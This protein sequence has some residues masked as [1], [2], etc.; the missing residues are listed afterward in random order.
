M[1]ELLEM[2]GICKYFPG[3]TALKDVD[4]IL[5]PGEVHALVGENGA[6]KSTLMKIMTGKY[7]P[8]EGTV[9]MEGKKLTIHSP[10][11]SIMQGISMI[12]QE[13]NSVPA[14]KVY[15]NIFLGRENQFKNNGL[16]SK[17]MMRKAAQPFLDEVGATFSSNKEMTE[18]N[19]AELQLVEIARA[20]SSNCKV[21][22]L[23]EP[24]SSLSNREVESL[25]GVI[26]RLKAKGIGLVFIGHRLEEVMRVA[27]R[28][29]VLRDGHLIET[30]E[31][32]DVTPQIM[33]QLMVGRDVS[34]IYPKVDAEIGDVTVSVRGYTNMP[35]FKDVSFDVRA[36]EI[37]GLGGLVGA[38][39]TETV[40]TIF[41]IRKKE[42]GQLFI[43]GKEVEI[44]K[45]ADAIKLGIGMIT[46]DRRRYGLNLAETVGSNILVMA[47]NMMKDK[48]GLISDKK[49][50]ALAK[51]QIETF[52]VKTTGYWQPVMNLSG[53]NQQKVIFAK[54]M[55][56]TPD[57][58]ILDEPTR[59]IDVGAK[60]EI[61][62]I[63]GELAKAGKTI[64]MISSEMP[65]LMGMTDRIL[66][67]YEG[68]PMGIVERKDYKEEKIM[69]LASG[70]AEDDNSA[71]AEAPADEKVT[72]EEAH[73]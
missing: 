58:L 13:L 22:V 1:S 38:G 47:T 29:T 62:K 27:D 33:V 8:D 20:I 63:I 67:M 19:I 9:S 16:V 56:N 28:V 41:G 30:R 46:E 66:V 14:M 49:G 26:D 68:K 53:G 40:E 52:N 2:R 60:A 6:G 39:R 70:Y 34:N 69:A 71:A 7:L 18:L 21:L 35:F 61:Y 24:T 11:D 3:V 5:R 4:F 37:F 64:I 25:F 42:A 15:E 51:K 32:K 72:E 65:E 45:P 50:Q 57:I 17:R 36:G 73:A 31:I 55:L 48:L 43:N 54:W 10:H 44:R 59:G 23:D 12:Y